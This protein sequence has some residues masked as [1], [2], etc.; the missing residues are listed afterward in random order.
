MAALPA[1]ASRASPP[2]DWLLAPFRLVVRPFLPSGDARRFCGAAGRRWPCWRCTICGW[3]ASDVAFE[4]ASIA[5]SQ[6]HAVRVAA[7]RE[8]S[9]QSARPAR[10]RRAPFRLAPTGPP[11]VAILWK[12]LLAR[13]AIVQRAAGARA[14]RLGGDR[15]HEL[16]LGGGAQTAWPQVVGTRGVHRPAAWSL[17]LGPQFVRQDFRQDLAVA[18]LLKMYPMRGWQVALGELLAPGGDPDR[19]A[20]GA[21][22]A[23]GH[24]AAS[25]AT[26]RIWPTTATPVP[27]H[28]ALASRRRSSSAAQPRVAA[29]PQRRRAA[30][31][32]VVRR[33]SGAARAAA[34]H[35]GH[36]PAAAFR[37]GAIGRARRGAAAG[38][39]AGVLSFTLFAAASV[40][41]AQLA[42]L[43]VAARARS[44]SVFAA[45]AVG[46]LGAARDIGSRTTT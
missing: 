2:A 36:G 8:G 40:P 35:R 22:R 15:G 33:S 12:N 43:P 29:H 4:E 30:A 23:G 10:K 7:M 42:A 28:A 16:R 3:C 11:A 1:D 18:D 27:T 19:R 31:A 20:M 6:R 5:A 21:H 38:G 32:R 24:A 14:P 41:A 9:W 13:G 37:A 26:R 34:R 39:G 17:L 46:G 44:R 25:A 45:E